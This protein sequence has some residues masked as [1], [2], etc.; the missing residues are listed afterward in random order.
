[1]ARDRCARIALVSTEDP[2]AE[3]PRR[4]GWWVRLAGE[5]LDLETLAAEVR[6]DG[7]FIVKL[8][9]RYYLY[10]AELQTVSN[11]ESA[12]VER[13]AAQI[14]RI[15]NGSSKLVHGNARE[16]TVEAVV[17]VG[18]DGHVQSLV[19]MSGT[20]RGRGRLSASFSGGN[21][22]VPQPPPLVS[23]IAKAALDDTEA[24]R[25][26]RRDDV[27]YRDLYHVFEIAQSALGSEM[28]RD[29]S[30]TRAD[31]SRFTHTA[32]SP[33]VLGDAARHGTERRAPPVHP[34]PFEQAAALVHR[35]LYL[36]LGQ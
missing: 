14:L 25:A 11:E 6:L 34:M 16:V 12:A 21:E 31:V 36:W 18:D 35:I 17:L 27:D 30:V 4:P 10:A 3:L 22:D 24:E 9:N 29:G 20:I 23:Q 32:Q 7:V 33:G 15:L 5:A 28:F 8:D 13:R 2:H 26:L 19:H 1:M